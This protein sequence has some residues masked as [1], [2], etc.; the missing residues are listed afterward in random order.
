[1]RGSIYD[2]DL[3]IAITRDNQLNRLNKTA[4]LLYDAEQGRARQLMDVNL[5]WV[6]VERL[7][8]TGFEP[9]SENGQIVDYA[10]S[11]L[12]LVGTDRR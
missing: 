8:L 6:N 3:A 10:Q 5:E 9:H 4:R 11:W 1:M 2:G 7:V 12:C